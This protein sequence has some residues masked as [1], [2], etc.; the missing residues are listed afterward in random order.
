MND[1]V[2][3]EEA[4]VGNL[5][6]CDGI[7][8]FAAVDPRE[9]ISE[10]IHMHREGAEGLVRLVGPLGML[11]DGRL[12]LNQGLV[13][14]ERDASLAMGHCDNNDGRLGEP[15]ARSDCSDFHSNDDLPA[16]K[17]F[18]LARHDAC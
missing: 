17:R 7:L 8:E 16:R 11:E 14:M 1:V 5:L 12:L 13:Q 10:G 4:Q 3:C 18:S 6:N 15:K 9:V 2:V